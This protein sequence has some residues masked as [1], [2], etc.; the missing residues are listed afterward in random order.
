MTT[1]RDY[2]AAAPV[3]CGVVAPGQRVDA[4]RAHS[5]K[6]GR[7]PSLVAGS[8]VYG[9]FSTWIGSPDKNRAWDLLCAAKASFD[10]VMASGSLSLEERTAAE[11]QLAVCEGSDWFWWFGDYNPAQ[12]VASFD[13]LYREHLGNLYRL[14][15]LPIPQTLAEPIS[16]GHG[17][18]EAGGAMRR[19][20]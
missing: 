4:A 20:S 5:A 3:E 19:A 2:L 11:R 7:L 16:A 15:K 10:E 17:H 1:F 9:T 8:W 12:S 13:R 14:L 6:P 18:P